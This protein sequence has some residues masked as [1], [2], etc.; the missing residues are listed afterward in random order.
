MLHAIV[1]ET[2][3]SMID[4][5]GHSDSHYLS[6]HDATVRMK[7]Y[8]RRLR[9]VSP[10]LLKT[11]GFLLGNVPESKTFMFHKTNWADG[12]SQEDKDLVY[13]YLFFLRFYKKL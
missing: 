9:K 10:S 12:I 11:S 5:S 2:A 13:F 8:T 7:Y 4:V 6:R 1:E 3:A